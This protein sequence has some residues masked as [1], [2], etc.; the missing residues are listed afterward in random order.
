VELSWQKRAEKCRPDNPSMPRSAPA[1]VLLLA[2]FL[3]ACSPA[4]N[5]REVR[6][7][8]S[9]LTALMPC[10]PE[11]AIR[12]VA[13]AGRD[14]DMQ[15]L[16]CDA[17]GATFALM[18]ADMADATRSGEALAQWKA[19]TLAHLRAATTAEKPFAP[20]GA[21][22]LGQ[23][24]R[25][26]AGGQRPDGSRVECQASYFAHDRYV[27]QAAIYAD[28]ISPEVADAFFGGLRFR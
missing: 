11:K 21:M 5:W 27:F 1:S 8:P 25:V 13:V 7:A 26:V 2:A 3:S 23:S 19:A 15:A 10:K 4:Y 9:T 28:R 16:G 18:F 12:P 24:L 22:P 14:V 17:G 6:A 20:P